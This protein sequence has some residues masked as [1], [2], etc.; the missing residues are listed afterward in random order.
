VATRE[1]ALPYRQFYAGDAKKATSKA[2]YQGAKKFAE[3]T[4]EEQKL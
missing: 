3:T 4:L 2:M 1:K